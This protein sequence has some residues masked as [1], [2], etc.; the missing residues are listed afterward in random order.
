MIVVDPLGLPALEWF[1]STGDNLSWI[2]APMK[3]QDVSEWKTW[4]RHVV[5]NPTIGG[6]SPPNP[7]QYDNWEEWAVRFNQTISTLRI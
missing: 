7:D 1:D 3:L 4:A 6:L 5:Q 2:V